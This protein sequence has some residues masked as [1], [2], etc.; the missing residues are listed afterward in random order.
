MLLPLLLPFGFDG[1]LDGWFD[2]GPA[3]PG[4]LSSR[5]L[6]RRASASAPAAAAASASAAP[7]YISSLLTSPLRPHHGQ[8]RVACGLPRGDGAHPLGMTL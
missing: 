3:A 2:L 5:S 1:W 8:Q 7:S 6:L 4:L